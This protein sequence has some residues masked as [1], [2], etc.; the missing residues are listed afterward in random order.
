MDVDWTIP[1]GTF[2]DLYGLELLEVSADRVTARVPVEGRHKQPYGLV[3]GGVHASIAESLASIGTAVG[4]A[5][6]GNIAMGSSNATTFLRPVTEGT[7]HAEATPLHRGRTQWVWDVEIR[8]DAGKLCATTRM[9][10][11]VRPKPAGA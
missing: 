3:H 4:V 6:A 7:L 10:I 11:A 8:N 2:D 9:T 5:E 1:A